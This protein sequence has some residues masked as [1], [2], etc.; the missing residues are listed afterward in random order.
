MADVRA[1]LHKLPGPDTEAADQ[2]AARERQLTKPQGSLGRLESLSEWL[3]SWQ[4]RSPPR[5]DRPAAR[6][7]AGNH[8]VTARG[9]S[10]FPAEVTAQ[11]VANFRAGGAAVNQLCRALSVELAVEAIA[12]DRPT[13]DFVEEPALSEEE[14]TD[15]FARGMAAVESPM[16]VVAL[17]EMGIGNTTA[18][19]AIAHALFGGAAADWTGPGTGV[20]GSALDHKAQVVEAAV[21]RHRTAASDALDVLRRLGGREL[22]AVAGAIVGARFARVPVLLDG[23]ICTAAAAPLA[24]MR[25]DAL[26]HCVAGHVSAEPGHRALLR[27]LNKEPALLDLGMR[28]GEA[29]GAVLAIAVLRAAAACHAGMATFAEAQVSDR[30]E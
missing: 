15:A 6:V 5:M 16:D 4:G 24:A 13:R 12:L 20:E 8:G 23:F 3:A 27:C 18:A 19:A 26:D 29:S 11:M 1:L 21:Q 10:A 7:F 22:V 14:F 17:G 28:L 25:P 30:E 2:V 9:V